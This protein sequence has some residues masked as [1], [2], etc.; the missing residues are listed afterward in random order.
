L[1]IAV[2]A[3]CLMSLVFGV[4]CAS[5][6]VPVTGDYVAEAP[7]LQ[8]GDRW[9]I[10]DPEH[11]EIIEKKVV[12]V[13]SNGDFTLML[14]T[15]KTKILY[16][17]CD[18]NHN[19]LRQEGVEPSWWSV[20]RN[21]SYIEY[22]L[23]V[24]K[25]YKKKLVGK[26]HSKSGTY[27]YV[28]SFYVSDFYEKEFLTKNIHVFKIS[29]E[30]VRL[31]DGWTG[32]GRVL[33]SPELKS[34]IKIVRH[35]RKSNDV[36]AFYVEPG[37][38]SLAQLEGSLM[39]VEVKGESRL[40]FGYEDV[41]DNSY[42]VA[43]ERKRLAEE[44]AQLENERQTS[45]ALAEE[46]LAEADRMAAARLKQAEMEAEQLKAE[47]LER[48]KA[49]ADQIV[50]EKLTM[51]QV[52]A[53][54]AATDELNE[55]K[56]ASERLLDEN[57]RL[58]VAVIIGN[59]RYSQNSADVPDVD[60]AH[61][62]AAAIHRYVKE[63]LG[64]QEANIFH[65]QD[66]TQAELTSIFGNERNH[67]GKL[68]SWASSENSK[69]FVYY[70]GHGAP[71]LSDGAGYLLPVNADPLTVDLN[72]YPLELLYKNLAK[73]PASQITVVLDACFSGS[74]ASGNLVT[75][76]S[77]IAL[78]RVEADKVLNN[79]AVLTAAALSEVASWDNDRQLGL[80]TATFL[81]G[82]N[83]KADEDVFGDGDGQVVLSE[84]K[85]YL[86]KTVSVTARRN[87][88]REQHPQITGDAKIVLGPLNNL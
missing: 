79:G 63:R 73:I 18:K 53:E 17:E 42:Q 62:D 23:F 24:G 33:Y 50:A 65:V 44:R 16:A 31:V 7:R 67:K 22:P 87:Y 81:D 34:I 85:S 86:A 74:S 49:K 78:R 66:A 45:A 56:A 21:G 15:N 51:E 80:F 26:S 46:R 58:G 57:R 35:W 1:R 69:V 70:S 72:G 39:P 59:K 75:S 30:V 55:K 9:K 6:L 20:W 8:V 84:L 37:V 47:A 14:T 41:D 64:Y 68:F 11:D 32:S 88:Y 10:N 13:K 28:Y 3:V 83:G 48:A 27:E 5:K 2:T 43:M 52:L 54:K 38:F 60:Y 25:R 29:F 36:F 71:G 61:N 77:S 82:V 40:A 76:A 19:I 4:S 12:E